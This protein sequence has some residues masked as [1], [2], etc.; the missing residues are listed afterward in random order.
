LDIDK[1]EGE[2]QPCPGRQKNTKEKNK[3]EKKKI[4]MPL[5]PEHARP[6]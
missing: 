5:W 3:K 6:T 1:D 4:S 2:K